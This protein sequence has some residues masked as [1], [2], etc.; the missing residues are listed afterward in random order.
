M[1]Q[2]KNDLPNIQRN[3]NKR[4]RMIEMKMAIVGSGDDK[5]NEIGA[6]NARNIIKKLLSRDKAELVSGHS[7]L[8]GIDIWAEEYADI[9][10]IRKYIF[11]PK[12]LQWSTGYRIRN[13]QI[14]KACDEIHVIVPESYPAN[15]VGMRFDECYHCGTTKHIK[16]GGCWT[17]KIAKLA[18][19]PAT[20]HIIRQNEYHSE[21][22]T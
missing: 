18:K 20:W 12:K 2:K 6:I 5:F 15:Y 7:H 8:G 11:P 17:A 4:Q 9:I 10:G 14:V 22:T 19:K 1:K 3:R 21:P 16:S 13:I